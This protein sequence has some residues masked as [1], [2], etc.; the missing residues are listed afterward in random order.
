MVPESSCDLKKH[1]TNARSKPR[2]PPGPLAQQKVPIPGNETTSRRPQPSQFQSGSSSLKYWG[3]QWAVTHLQISSH[4]IMQKLFISLFHPRITLKNECFIPRE[5]MAVVTKGSMSAL[6]NSGFCFQIVI[7]PA[8][9][10]NQ[11]S[12]SFDTWKIPYSRIFLHLNRKYEK[13]YYK[14][15]VS[16][17]SNVS[18]QNDLFKN[19]TNLWWV[20]GA[21]DSPSLKL[22]VTVIKHLRRDG[23]SS[24][25]VVGINYLS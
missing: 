7:G 21:E 12:T 23:H 1:S 15:R 14:T 25:P 16:Y 22:T 24:K 11:S 6:G 3:W 5:W 4:S 8:K 13:L 9:K 10:W 20:Y 18:Y 19:I 17:N 2:G